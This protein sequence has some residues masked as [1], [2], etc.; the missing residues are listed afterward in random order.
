MPHVFHNKIA[1]MPLFSIIIPLYNKEHTITNSIGSVLDQSFQDFEIIIVDDGSTDSSADKVRAFADPRIKLFSQQNAG[2][3]AARNHGIREATGEWVVFLDADDTLSSQALMVFSEGI[4]HYPNF[5][6]FVGNM[7]VKKGKQVSPFLRYYNPG[8]INNPFK[9]AFF[10]RLP[11]S[12]G[13][14]AINRS[15]FRSILYNESIKR[16]EDWDFAIKL[17]NSFKGIKL[18][19]TVMF[20]NIDYLTAS[21]R[22]E[23]R[24]E[25]F[26]FHIDLDKQKFWKRLLLFDLYLEGKNLYSVTGKEMYKN[27]DHRYGLLLLDILL[28]NKGKRLIQDKLH[29]S[30]M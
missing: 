20:Y 19:E 4:N 30:S 3:S 21:K 26:L 22:I 27:Y 28:L 23:N 18:K 10:R 12:A 8:L 14:M 29:S 16:C 13:T 1:K 5:H 24:K 7:K 9:E 2:P 11:I 6:Y 17:W 15:V 25:D